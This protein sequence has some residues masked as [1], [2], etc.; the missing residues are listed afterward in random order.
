MDTQT[1][2]TAPQSPQRATAWSALR[3]AVVWEGLRATSDLVSAPRSAVATG[4]T[5]LDA[6]GGTG[7]QAV[8]LA[9]LGH[10][11]VV[12]D[13]SPD[14]LAALE[15][16]ASDSSVAGRVRWVQGDL[17]QLRELVVAGQVPSPVELALCHSVL[18]FADDPADGIAATSELLVPGGVLSIVAS[19]RA[20]AVLGRAIAGQFAA[21]SAVLS[22]ADAR[23]TGDSVMRRFDRATLVDMVVRSGLEVVAVHGIRVVSDLVPG[24]LL[25]SDPVA[26]AALLE[27]E[28]S[29][30][31]RPEF[32]DVATQLHV[33]ARKR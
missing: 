10:D 17:G 19:T 7:G 6:G 2:G 25:D 5:V 31:V 22:D 29:L 21:A 3:G 14:S 27:L 1:S 28:R 4:K 15:R 23:W 8:P 9:E 12:V 11:V 16:R 30:S 13:P 20:G 26:T 32:L 24:G 33:I 18:E